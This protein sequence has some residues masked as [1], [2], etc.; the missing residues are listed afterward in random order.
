M[1]NVSVWRSARNN[2]IFAREKYNRLY[3][4]SIFYLQMPKTIKS[5]L[6][7]LRTNCGDRSIHRGAEMRRCKKNCY[8][9]LH[10]SNTRTIRS[11]RPR[12]KLLKYSDSQT[13]QTWRKIHIFIPWCIKA[14]EKKR[15]AYCK[16]DCIKT[17][18][19][20]NKTCSND[21]SIQIF[22]FFF[23]WKEETCKLT[24]V[25]I[26]AFKVSAASHIHEIVIHLKCKN[27]AQR[28]YLMETAIYSQRG[29][30]SLQF[31]LFE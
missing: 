15:R 28:R 27:R 25:V 13:V 22:F 11:L 21:Q 8:F 10:K 30:I 18:F 7:I 29:K 6:K 16:Y 19:F 3:I 17:I 23:F 24:I 9:F 4:A 20:M 12:D 2:K 5:D 14:T 26:S 1:R 31:I